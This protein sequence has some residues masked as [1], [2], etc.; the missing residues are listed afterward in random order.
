MAE[1]TQPFLDEIRA[2]LSLVDY[3]GKFVKLH[4]KGREFWACCPFHREKTPS[5]S[6]SDE[7]GYYHCFGCGAHGD[8][9]RFVQEYEKLSFPETVERLAA[10]AGLE[11]PKGS[12]KE[13]E[14][15]KKREVLYDIL[16]K[17]CAY[18]HNQLLNSP[19][20]QRGLLYLQERG[21]SPEIIKKFRLGF[22]SFGN[23]LRTYL[24]DLQIPPALAKEAGVLGQS[25]DDKGY[26]DYFRERVIFPIMDKKNRVIAFGGRVIEK[27]EPKYLNSP[28]SALFSKRHC[29]FA[30]NFAA[31]AARRENKIIAVEGYMDAISLHAAGVNYA[32]AP[33]GTALTE[34]QIEIMWKSANEPVLCFDNDGAGHKAAFRACDRALPLLKA[35]KSLSFVFTPDG[36]K[37]PDEFV[38]AQG[39]FAFEEIVKTKSLSLSEFLWRHLYAEKPTDTP[40]RMADLEKRLTDAAGKI[41]DPT[42]RNFYKQDWKKKI[43]ELNRIQPPVQTRKTS[44]GKTYAPRASSFAFASA[45][46]PPKPDLENADRLMLLAYMLKF[47]QTASEF[48]ED[49]AEYI[50]AQEKFAAVFRAALNALGDNPDIAESDLRAYLQTNGF[51]Y[52]YADLKEHLELLNKRSFSADIR[53]DFVLRLKSFAKNG[54]KE[55]MDALSRRMLNA[56]EDQAAELWRQYQTLRAEYQKM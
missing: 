47:P 51:G 2:R 4:R 55:E 40:E 36:Y 7:R 14:E 1:F 50:P 33:L 16:E 39:K 12:P 21:L 42:V 18:Y 49:L 56:P 32:V 13:R 46:P 24:N 28:E 37:D 35:G 38:K 48:V 8:I 34:N 17:T 54:L 3:V 19:I 11:L 31:D 45:E 22:A 15:A 20:G 41:A 43:W 52:V 9:I 5:F 10:L 6:V 44:G 30:F 25:T 53:E 23:R 27:A 26:F 29:L